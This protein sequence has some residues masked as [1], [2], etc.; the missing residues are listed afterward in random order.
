M[1]ETLCR[2]LSSQCTLG[3]PLQVFQSVKVCVCFKALQ[4][5]RVKLRS[6]TC[7]LSAGEPRAALLPPG[8]VPQ[9]HAVI[10]GSRELPYHQT[11]AR[12]ETMYNFSS[13]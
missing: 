11:A 12:R 2:F 13:D 8:T 5:Q 10:L 6:V 3:I 9:E 4:P 1:L 7:T